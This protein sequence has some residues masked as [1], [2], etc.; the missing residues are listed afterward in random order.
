MSV[1]SVKKIEIIQAKYENGLIFAQ[2]S[3]E[4]IFSKVTDN[5][6]VIL[7]DVFLAKEVA[8]I[9]HAV[10]QWGQIT[11]ATNPEKPTTSW[12][13]VDDNPAKSQ[14]KHRFVCYMFFV[15]ENDNMIIDKNGQELGLHKLLMPY[16][17]AL[18]EFQSK[19]TKTQMTFSPVGPGNRLQ[20]QI[21]HYPVGGGFF[22]AHAHSLE[23]QKAGLILGLSQQGEDFKTGGTRFKLGEEWVSVEDHMNMGDITIF[24][25]DLFH[26]VSLV[27]GD[28][29]L[30]W[31][32]E[33]GRWTMVIP[34]K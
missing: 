17:K 11:P 26:D 5:S 20:P 29:F 8:E 19:L 32:S 10:H 18:G 13:R 14:T 24:K 28:E 34:F 6:I 1:Q 27:D 16:F 22:N 4:R 7:K 15:D 12:H 2:E 31:S 25:Y 23:P 21:I 30:D 33:Y 9:R 3:Y